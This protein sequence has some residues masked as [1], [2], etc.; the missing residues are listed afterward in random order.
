MGA[1]RL[2]GQHQTV[3]PEVPSMSGAGTPQSMLPVMRNGSRHLPVR[4]RTPAPS[5]TSRAS[6]RASQSANSTEKLAWFPCGSCTVWAGSLSAAASKAS[7][8]SF[9]M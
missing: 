4:K 5:S 7:R 3:R 9:L 2:S 8:S 6:S 1:Q